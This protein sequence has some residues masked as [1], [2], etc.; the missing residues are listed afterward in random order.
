MSPSGSFRGAGWA[1]SLR[2]RVRQKHGAL[3]DSAAALLATWVVL[4][5]TLTGI[6]IRHYDERDESAAWCLN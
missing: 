5:S 4:L 1:A 2:W 3:C 6:D